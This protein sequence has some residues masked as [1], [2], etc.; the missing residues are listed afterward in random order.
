MATRRLLAELADLCERATGITVCVESVG[1]IDAARRVRAGE[2]YDL[3]VLAAD[4]IDDL[5]DEGWV[6]AETR[7]SLA[8]S[9]VAIAMR[10]GTRL[11]DVKT[12]DALCQAVLSANRIGYS[13]GPSGTALMALFAR[14]GVLDALRGRLVQARPGTPVASLI[15]SRQVEL[16]FQQLSELKD[17]AGVAVLGLM[18]PGIEIVTTFAGV[19]GR[20]CMQHS[21]ARA[22][23]D[24]LGS[25]AFN[26]IKFRCGMAPPGTNL[27]SK[28][29]LDSDYTS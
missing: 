4:T 9:C 17:E 18:P 10:S 5:A 6:L 11:Y 19:V 20:G 22:V 8:E 2:S 24:V 15:A 14:W 3:I 28:T 7:K 25:P 1:G 12:E 21:A 27:S 29:S 16:G 23:L 13:S 26:E